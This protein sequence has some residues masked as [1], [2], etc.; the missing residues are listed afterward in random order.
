MLLLLFV[1]MDG[2][3]ARGIK[4]GHGK[5]KIKIDHFRNNFLHIPGNNIIA[6]LQS[7]RRILRSN[8][9]VLPSSGLIDTEL[10]LSFSLQV[11]SM[12]VYVYPLLKTYSRTLLIQP[13]ISNES[14]KFGRITLA[15]SNF[16]TSGP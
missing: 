7:S 10:D 11:S 15:G 2:K 4:H 5:T 1:P 3:D 8:E 16:M 13:P 12:I 14:K 9:I 6:L